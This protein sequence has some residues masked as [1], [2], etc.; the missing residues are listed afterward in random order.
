MFRLL[1]WFLGKDERLKTI[2]SILR[3][4]DEKC[5]YNQVADAIFSNSDNRADDLN[6]FISLAM[7]AVNPETKRPLLDMRY[8]QLFRGLE[9]VGVSFDNAQGAFKLHRSEALECG[10]DGNKRAVFGLGVCRTCGQP[11]LMGYTDCAVITENTNGNY[12]SRQQG[13]Q[14]DMYLHAIAWK[15]GKNYPQAEDESLAPTNNV[16]INIMSGEVCIQNI[17]PYGDVGLIGHWYVAP[18]AG[19]REFLKECPCCRDSQLPKSNAR[20]GTITPY[21]FQS[22]QLQLALLEQLARCSDASIDPSARQHPGGGRKVLAFSDSRKGASRLALQFQGFFDETTVWRLIPEA[23]RNVDQSVLAQMK[24]EQLPEIARRFTPVEAFISDDWGVDDVKYAIQK[25]IEEK[26]CSRLLEMSNENG[27]DIQ[28]VE[29]AKFL[30][31]RAL[32]RKGRHSL[33]NKGIIRIQCKALQYARKNQLQEWKGPRD[34]LSMSGDDSFSELLHDLHLAL[35]LRVRVKEYGDWPEESGINGWHKA[36][37]RDT[38]NQG[39]TLSFCGGNQKN[40]FFKIVSNHCPDYNNKQQILKDIW[41]LYTKKMGASSVLIDVGN[42]RYELNIDDVCLSLNDPERSSMVSNAWH[43]QYEKH[44]AEREIIPLRIEEH[45]AQLGKGRGAAYQRAFSNG[46]INILS[47]STTFEMGVDLGDLSCVFMGNLPPSTANYRQRAGRA[48]RRPGSAAYVLTFAGNGAH[49]LYYFNKAHELFFGRVQMPRIYLE[50]KVFRAR[51]LR[52]EALH[53]F[54]TWFKDKPY[55]NK[56]HLIGYFLLGLKCGRDPKQGVTSMS[57]LIDSIIDWRNEREG[58]LYLES[59]QDVGNLD[60]SVANDLIWQLVSQMELRPYDLIS[61]NASAYHDL[62]GPNQPETKDEKL[63]ESSQISRRAVRA[64]AEAMYREESENKAL[65]ALPLTPSRRHLLWESTITWLTRTRV[66]PK[67]GFP[68]DVVQLLPAS[69]DV[70]G[71]NVK[72]ER[73]LK[74]GLYEYA[75]DQSVMADKRVYTSEAVVVYQPGG[76]NRVVGRD[77]VRRVYLC[78]SCRQPHSQLPKSGNC[79]ACG[80]LIT[81]ENQYKVITPDAFRAKRSRAANVSFEER[82]VPRKLFTGGVANTI[83]IQGTGFQTCESKD[84]ELLYLNF[85]K[86]YEGFGRRPDNYAL[87]HAVRTDIVIWLL[88][89]MPFGNDTLRQNIAMLSALEA[90]KKA[91]ALE[92]QVS[93]REIDGIIYH[94]QGGQKGFVLFDDATGGGGVVLPLALSGNALTDIKRCELI[95]QIIHRAIMLCKECPECNKTKPFEQLDPQLP[96]VSHEEILIS[97]NGKRERQACYKCLKSYANQRDHHALDRVDA[98]VVLEA[99]LTKSNNCVEVQPQPVQRQR[100][101]FT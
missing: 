81:D 42:G 48:G 77:D 47:C 17:N 39:E 83:Y 46:G 69:D 34:A 49:D 3:L 74:I 55:G 91:I 33:I 64:R 14:T 1:A 95:T 4:N 80:Q 58:K 8:H 32:R 29:A 71:S 93:E 13:C 82:G 89:I 54:L 65:A 38:T 9:E 57:P 21:S 11:F 94:G 2:D 96:S 19:T 22:S 45:T 67:Y 30:L 72:L 37:S 24:W 66:L 15:Q 63:I 86:S 68:V 44:L 78:P 40:I 10:E 87:Y 75:P 61:E 43:D 25:L 60:Y 35:F 97:P 101:N 90:I 18:A 56:W 50:N 52:A 5:R 53:D 23:M 100:A 99:L 31:L 20:F 76:I 6:A 26:N 70:H 16:W 62:A 85:G 73:D 51:H 36:I 12:L 84:G 88:N 28:D 92:F 98:V 59:L 41:S 27:E 7:L 79:D